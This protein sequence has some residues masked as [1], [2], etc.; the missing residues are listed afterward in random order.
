MC[1]LKP[2]T[3]TMFDD[4]S[5]YNIANWATAGL[6]STVKGAIAPEKPFSAQHW[7]DSLATASLI[8]PVINKVSGIKIP[9]RSVSKSSPISAGDSRRI[10]NAANKTKQTITVVGSRANGTAGLNS[11]W[12]Y[13]LS[14]NSAQRHSAASSLPCGAWGG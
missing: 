7:V 8:M 12:D 10:Q 5:V 13:I 14:G 2:R 9:T 4:P 11:D 3:Q 1:V 6:A